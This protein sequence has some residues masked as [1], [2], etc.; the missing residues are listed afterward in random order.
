MVRGMR[1]NN[2]GNIRIGPAKWRG[3][4]S[5]NTDGAFEQFE[6]FTY[7]V[8]ALIILLKNYMNRSKCDTVRKIITR[9]APGH[10][11][12]TDAY[13]ISVALGVGVSPDEVL[14]PNKCTL[15][16]LVREI[17]KFENGIGYVVSSQVF[18]D[19]WQMI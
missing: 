18:N 7:G 15:R 4:V 2:P 6:T 13:V 12:P 9:Y 1:N 3:K 10:E 17:T 8:R 19:A 5:N 14:E 11:N 16:L